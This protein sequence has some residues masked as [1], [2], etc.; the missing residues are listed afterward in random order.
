MRNCIKYNDKDIKILGGYDTVVVGGGSAGASAAISA[1]KGGTKTLIIEKQISLGGTS[2]NALVSPMMPSYVE[3]FENFYEI[4][5]K[6]IEKGCA[7]RDSITEYVWFNPEVMAE[8]LEEM[9]IGFGGDILYDTVLIDCIKENNVIKYLILMTVE[10][11]TAVE[12]R[13]FI[14]ASGDAIL[15][16]LAS[17]ETTSGDEDGNNQMS[18]LRFEVGGINVDKYRE[19]CISLNDEFSPLKT[20]YFFES[21]MVKGK[22]FKLEPI[23]QKGVEEGILKNEDLRYYQCFSLP[24][25]EG[26]MT[27]NCPHISTLTNN[28]SVIN[29]SKAI[30]EGRQMIHRLVGFLKTYMPGFEN[31]FLAREASMLG[32]R[33][34]YRLVGKYVLTEEDYINREHFEDGIAKGDWYID[35]HS[36]SKGL[37][38]MDKFKPG[39]YYEIPY[40]SLINSSVSN[41]ITVGRCISTTFLMQASVRIL[42]TVIDMGQI[43]GEACVYAKK[44]GIILNELNGSKL[45]KF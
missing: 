36:A 19:Y 32:I 16:R 33:E 44:Y 35:V 24:L 21:A 37:V 14:D 13:N 5:R 38:H 23:F 20:G 27:F 2:T 17:V 31:C 22:K 7:T 45:R 26:C 6:L 41:L 40:R 11:I 29:R 3:H 42:P 10:G 34:S 30:I 4:E 1:A 8:I 9:Y 39:E 43:A 25:K 12:G 18:S 28:T 15:T